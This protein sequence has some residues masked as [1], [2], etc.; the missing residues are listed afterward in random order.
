LTIVTRASEEEAGEK[1]RRAGADTVFTP[2]A[3]AGR[4]LADALVRPHVVEFL[5]FARSNMGP[6]VTMEQVCVAPK[7]DFTAKPLGQL[8]ELRKSGVIV[9]AIR[10][11]G[12]ETIF[13][14]SAE[15]EI[16]AGDFLIVMGERTSLQKLEQILT[17]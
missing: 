15:F 17:S 8:M 10:K 7:A 9:L 14:P 5:D 11:R 12:G 6:K 2:Y 4:Q 3:M 1:L 16:S 13:N